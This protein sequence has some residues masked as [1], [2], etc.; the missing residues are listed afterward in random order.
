MWGARSWIRARRGRFA[1][2]NGARIDLNPSAPVAACTKQSIQSKAV[3][4]EARTSSFDHLT[5][6]VS[7]PVSQSVRPSVNQSLSPFFR[8]PL[9]R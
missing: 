1:I 6:A 3:R 4:M 9:G 2:A 5:E 7:R 8:Q